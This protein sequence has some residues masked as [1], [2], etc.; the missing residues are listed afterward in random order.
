MVVSAAAVV[1][2]EVLAA[3]EELGAGA[4]TPVLECLAAGPGREGRG[5]GRRCRS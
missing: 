5:E 1:C 4:G 3:G 2:R